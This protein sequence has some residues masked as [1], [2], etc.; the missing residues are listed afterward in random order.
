STGRRLRGFRVPAS[1]AYALSP[2]GKLLAT[3]ADDVNQPF[4]LRNSAV[5]LWDLATGQEVRRFQGPAGHLVTSVAFS[6]DGKTLATAGRGTSIC[7]WDVT[8][9]RE[10]SQL[11]EPQWE[12]AGQRHCR[13]QV[14]FAGDGKRLVSVR[15]TTD[16]GKPPGPVPV[17]EWDLA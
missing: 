13:C 3:T 2:D 10:L 6:P 14:A 1:G 9:G 11:S 15:W 8:A 17:R 12:G 16:V 5:L 4:I 7:L